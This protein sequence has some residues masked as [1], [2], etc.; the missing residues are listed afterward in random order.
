MNDYI[1]VEATETKNGGYSFITRAS[2]VIEG[3]KPRFLNE[4]VK[5][6]PGCTLTTVPLARFFRFRSRCIRLKR[7]AIE[8]HRPYIFSYGVESGGGRHDEP[9]ENDIQG[10]MDNL[11]IK[12]LHGLSGF[13]ILDM[14]IDQNS[15]Y[16]NYNRSGNILIG[17]DTISKMD[18]HIGISKETGKLIFLACPYNLLNDNY[19]DAIDRHFHLIRR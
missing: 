6:D 17:M 13:S 10:L 11:A 9:D 1:L 2:F 8:E 19:Y 12:F 5:I 18:S 4:T 15:I 3:L 14:P 7:T 16:V